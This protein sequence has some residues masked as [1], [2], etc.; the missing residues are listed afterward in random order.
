MHIPFMSF[1]LKLWTS[2]YRTPQFSSAHGEISKWPPT[3]WCRFSSIHWS[4]KWREI[5]RM[6]LVHSIIQIA[7]RWHLDVSTSTRSNLQFI[8]LPNNSS[9]SY[10][11]FNFT[12][13]K[14]KP[15][16]WTFI[17]RYTVSMIINPKLNNKSDPKNMNKY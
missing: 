4:L 17:K 5:C 10:G 8:I 15:T 16:F 14:K 13:M 12:L 11:H 3:S 7:K 1:I 2:I 6:Y 9:S